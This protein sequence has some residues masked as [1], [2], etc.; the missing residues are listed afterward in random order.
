M[1][2]FIREHDWSA[3]L[4]EFLG[5]VNQATL[6]QWLPR[7]QALQIEQRDTRRDRLEQANLVLNALQACAISSHGND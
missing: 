3:V 1:A 6:V 7:I 2:R 5:A 4:V